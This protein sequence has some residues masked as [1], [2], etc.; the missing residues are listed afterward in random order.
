MRFSDE[1]PAEQTSCSSPKQLSKTLSY[2]KCDG[3]L[4]HRAASISWDGNCLTSPN[5]ITGSSPDS[6]ARS[7]VH[8]GVAHGQHNVQED[9]PADESSRSGSC[10]GSDSD[11]ES[12]ACS[13]A[14]SSAGSS[15]VGGTAGTALSAGLSSSVNTA[16]NAAL[17]FS[18]QSSLNALA[19]DTRHR[20][21]HEAQQAQQAPESTTDRCLM[22]L[23]RLQQPDFMP[24]GAKRNSD[25]RL[26]SQVMNHISAGSRTSSDTRQF[27]TGL[28]WQNSGWTVPFDAAL[29]RRT[30]PSATS[31]TAGEEQPELTT[32]LSWHATCLDE[33][34]ST[35]AM[36]GTADVANSN[37]VAGAVGPARLAD[38]AL[39]K[40][41]VST[42]GS[43]GVPGLHETAGRAEGTISNDAMLS[44]PDA[45][46]VFIAAQPHQLPTSAILPLSQPDA[47]EVTTYNG[48]QREQQVEVE[49]GEAMSS[50]EARQQSTA[51]KH[52]KHGRISRSGVRHKKHGRHD[53]ETAMAHVEDHLQILKHVH[54][55]KA[56]PRYL[57]AGRV[58]CNAQ[59]VLGETVLCKVPST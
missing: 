58:T 18:S 16:A 2:Q 44:Q 29:V 13:E 6:S 45:A 38:A 51:A 28:I 23:S 9:A 56:S 54:L 55:K 25:S 21:Q 19:A 53:K 15:E 36:P 32:S 41:V 24:A 30:C 39:S 42:E 1:S 8:V 22:P 11:S 50:T 4:A 12:E 57:I 17:Y 40:Q 27:Q 5:T 31:E 52:A 37:Q 47:E 7:D 49:A 26:S 10:S 14:N 20:P 48:I 46:S 35:V 3:P 59:S 33:M 34:D 43:A